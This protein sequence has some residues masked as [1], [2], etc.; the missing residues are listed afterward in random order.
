MTKWLVY[1]VDS[2]VPGSPAGQ[3]HFVVFLAKT[4]EVTLKGINKGPRGEGR[5]QILFVILSFKNTSYLRGC[6]SRK[7]FVLAPVSIKP[8]QIY[9]KKA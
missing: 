8:Q 7:K 5:T 9:Q 1:A 4:Q 6:P 3:S 2:S